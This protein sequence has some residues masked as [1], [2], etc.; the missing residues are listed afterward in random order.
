MYYL[1]LPIPFS[2]LVSI[3]TTLFHDYS[4]AIEKVHQTEFVNDFKG[5]DTGGNN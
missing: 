4:F 5:I 2:P 1:F 3:L